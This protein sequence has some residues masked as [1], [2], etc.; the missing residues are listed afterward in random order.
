M[1]HRNQAKQLAY[2]VL[3]GM[4]HARL[5]DGLKC[6]LAEAKEHQDAFMRALPGLVGAVPTPSVSMQLFLL[7]LFGFLSQSLYGR[8]SPDS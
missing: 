2:G 6:S 7:L 3:Y 1:E 8:D 4:G 5:A